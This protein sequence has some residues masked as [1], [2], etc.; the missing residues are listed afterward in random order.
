M[1]D[2]YWRQAVAASNQAVCQMFFHAPIPMISAVSPFDGQMRDAAG[3]IY[4]AQ[5]GVAKY[6]PAGTNRISYLK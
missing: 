3:N 4:I 5:D 1:A 2:D 6:V